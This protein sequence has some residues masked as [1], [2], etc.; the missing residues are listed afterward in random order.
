[1]MDRNTMIEIARQ[2][3]H[4]QDIGEIDKQ[5][6][7]YAGDCRFKMPI[8]ETPM[9]GLAEL[10]KSVE[11]WPKAETEAEWFNAEGNRLVMCWNWRGVGD[12]WPANAPLLRGI[13]IFVFNEDGLIEEYEDFFDPDWMTRHQAAA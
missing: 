2:A 11:R 8:N 4:F 3:I 7:L 5:L 13:S 6:A 1:M 12:T 9:Q 10:R